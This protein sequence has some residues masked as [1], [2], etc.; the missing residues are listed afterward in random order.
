MRLL[1][2][3]TGYFKCDGGALFSVVPKVMWSKQVKANVNNLVT[4]SMRCLLVIDGERKILIDAGAGD[5]YDDK[6]KRNNGLHGEDTLAGSLQKAGIQPE[7]ITDVVFT[8]LHWDHCNGAVKYAANGTDQELL[9]PNATHWASTA[10]WEN[11]HNANPREGNAYMLSDL[12]VFEKSGKLKLID[13]ERFLFPN[14]EIRIFN[15]HTPGMM[16]PVVHTDNRSV[17]FAADLFPVSANVPPTWLASYDLYPVTAM[18]EKAG[19]LK[20]V[21]DKNWILFFEHDKNIECAEVE[22]TEKGLK[23]GKIYQLKEL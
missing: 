10:Q 9:F 17:V 16:V 2:I 23:A 15:G 19:F 18:E 21:S 3:E 8:H 14:F 11:S 20:E 12:D 7:E 4:C 1:S 13:Q 22:Q 6:F 5:K